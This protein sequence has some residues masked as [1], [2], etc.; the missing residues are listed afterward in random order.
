MRWKILVVLF[1]T[2]ASMAFQFAALGAMGPLYADRLGI[3][4]AGLGTLIG[5]YF[6][7]GIFVSLPGGTLG[8]RFGDS[9]VVVA[10]L[11]MMT[12]G[13]AAMA[14]AQGWSAQVAGRAL[15]GAG[16]VL[17][18]VSMTKMTADWFAGAE[19]ATAMAVFIN[20]W[21][22]GIAL[23]LLVMPA[24]AATLGLAGALWAIPVLTLGGLFLMLRFYRDP[25]VTG[26]A[27][28]RGIAPR[29][30][31]LA[32]ITA[33]G[34]AWGLFNAALAMV[35]SFGPISLVERG[36]PLIQASAA[37]SIVIWAVMAAGF[38]GGVIAD[39][40]GRPLT[41]LFGGTAVMALA[42]AAFPATAH[43]YLMLGL[44]GLA[45]GLP[46][47]IYVS[48]AARGLAP[49]ERAI[50]MGIFYTVY[51]VIFAAAPPLGGYLID[52]TGSSGAA[53][54]YGAAMLAVT[55]AA[56]AASVALQRGLAPEPSR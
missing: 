40:T 21:P 10:G 8:A 26:G 56:L 16:G 19:I 30:A 42:M 3:S 25:P 54:L 45:T 22:A 5:L 12:L 44:I 29:G 1:L 35:F 15:A 7:P 51:Y 49:E 24:L 18:N 4:L 41:V 36:L 28:P 34:L 32:A 48:T 13:G 11:T 9:R 37:T 52:A 6:L 43:F 38:S 47:G 46:A 53:F 27:P 55:L 39:R 20:S 14:A 23:A 31:A 2:R 50:G 17:L 33:A